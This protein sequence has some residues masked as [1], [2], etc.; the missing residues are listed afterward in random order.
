MNKHAANDF[1]FSSAAQAVDHNRS[2]RIARNFATF[3]PLGRADRKSRRVDLGDA[4]LKGVDLAPGHEVG[5][6][7]LKLKRR[8][9]KS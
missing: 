9:R 7:D 6:V 4:M 1:P 8:S 2:I 5:P 3:L